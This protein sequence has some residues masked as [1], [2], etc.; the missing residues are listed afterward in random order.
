MN[1][2]L[3]KLSNNDFEKDFFKLVNNAVSGKTMENIRKHRDIKLVTTDK[4]RS[5]LVSEPNYHTMY[6][7]SEDL[8]IIEMNKTKV[9][10]N[11][12]IYLGLSILEISRLLMY[13]FWYDYMKPKYGN[14]LKLC[15]M[16]TD[17][18]IRNIKTEDF[19]Q[20]I[21]ND[22]EK[23]SD[24]SNY[25]VNRPLPTGKNKKVIGLMKDELGGKM[26]TEFVT[27][28]PKTYS[29]LTDDC[30]EEKKTKGTNKCVIKRMIKF[31][32]YKNCLLKDEVVLK[33]Q[34][35]F[36]SKGH[37]VYTENINKIALSNNDD[38]RIVSSDKITSYPYGYKGKHAII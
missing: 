20:D 32:D 6:Y 31:N 36:K 38:K 28:I 33:L 23:R 11:K 4:K 1:T 21:A 8:S 3:R 27:L 15:Y 10:M 16:D 2:E 12:P 17:S 30:K 18:F 37:D 13:E 19:Y 25:E 7:I 24:T 35:R 22:V 9:K 29:Y 5:K 14:N 34:Q 26:I